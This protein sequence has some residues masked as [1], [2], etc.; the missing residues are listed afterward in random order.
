MVTNKRRGDQDLRRGSASGYSREKDT[1]NVFLFVISS[2]TLALLLYLK[3][4]ESIT[5]KNYCL[6]YSPAY[7]KTAYSW[8]ALGE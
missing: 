8:M 2:L 7:Q 6:R 5:F 1:V 4:V 3:V